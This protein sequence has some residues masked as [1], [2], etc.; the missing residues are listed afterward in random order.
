[1]NLPIH[2]KWLN[3]TKAFHLN[4]NNLLKN[5]NITTGPD[6][7]T[8]AIFILLKMYPKN[9]LT[10]VIPTQP[11]SAASNFSIIYPTYKQDTNIQERDYSN[12][13]PLVI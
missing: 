2:N 10:N 1:M 13:K 12:L 5:F 8:L 11:F 9:F 7:W 4:N 6:Y 3:I